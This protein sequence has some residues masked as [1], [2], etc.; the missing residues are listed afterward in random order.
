MAQCSSSCVLGIPDWL[1]L[2]ANISICR[3]AMTLYLLSSFGQ[4]DGPASRR[5]LWLWMRV[6]LHSRT[7]FTKMALNKRRYAV[8]DY[9]KLLCICVFC[10]GWQMVKSFRMCAMLLRVLQ[11]VNHIVC[12]AS[13]P[14]SLHACPIVN[15]HQT[16][17]SA[18]RSSHQDSRAY[19]VCIVDGV[20]IVRPPV[21]TLDLFHL[22]SRECQRAPNP[23]PSVSH[24]HC[25]INHTAA[26]A[27]AVGAAGGGT[28]AAA[29]RHMPMV[30]NCRKSHDNFSLHFIHHIYIFACAHWI[31]DLTAGLFIICVTAF[32]F[33]SSAQP[34]LMINFIKIE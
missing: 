3:I 34:A 12:I 1:R 2:R 4:T 15:V 24:T 32:C 23:S 25:F 27:A 20:A 8:V 7:I 29:E 33:S 21:D 6:V 14:A 17:G 28:A 19:Y 9:N 31:V 13:L 26:A 16:S 11:V 5:K 10:G 30:T 18:E 22:P